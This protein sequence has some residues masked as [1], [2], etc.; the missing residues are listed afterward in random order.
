MK[1]ILLLVLLIVIT[2]FYI[3]YKKD[4]K[5]KKHIAFYTVFVGS[6]K[7]I[8]FKTTKIPSEFYDCYY[9]TNN[10]D[11]IKSLKNTKWK[12]RYLN[13]EVNDDENKSCMDAK[14]VKINP[15]LYDELN[16]YDYTVFFDNKLTIN[17]VNQIERLINTKLNTSS[18]L[19][20]RHD[21]IDG[22]VMKEYNESMKQRRYEKE[23]IKYLDYINSQRVKGLSLETE[24]HYRCGFIIRKN[25]SSIVKEF[26]ETWFKHLN[27]C[28]IQDQIS[29]FFV[30]QLYKNDIDII[31]HKE[32][33][34][35]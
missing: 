18:I 34:I 26:N 11:I 19:L 1:S 15:H 17:N 32:L 22:N 7:N 21:F 8:A 16:K 24:D 9:Y 5:D 20:R 10:N 23:K 4:K 35:S 25:S 12:V 31:E 6:N 27:Q 30:K 13:Y 28:G 33:T 2:L 14:H 3:I 29:F